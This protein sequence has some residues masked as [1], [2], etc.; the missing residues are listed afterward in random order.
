MP[1]LRI[2]PWL[3]VLACNP[4]ATDAPPPPPEPV[5]LDAAVAQV[6]LLEGDVRVAS[7][8]GESPAEVGLELFRPDVLTVPE[9]GWTV[10][11]LHNHYLVRLDD[12]LTVTVGELDLIDAEP[13]D[14]TRDEQLAE[15]LDPAEREATAGAVRDERVVGW[16]A[17]RSAGT[18]APP[19]LAH[20]SNLPHAVEP[21]PAADAPRAVASAE[22]APS[23]PKSA[24]RA[25]E[26]ATARKEAESAHIR[27]PVRQGV[28]PQLIGTRGQG[29]DDTVDLF[30]GGSS[31]DSIDEALA[32]GGGPDGIDAPGTREATPVVDGVVFGEPDGVDPEEATGVLRSVIRRR[33]GQLRYCYDK[34]LHVDPELSGRITM[35]W[36]VSGGRVTP[37]S[38][39]VM[40]DT[41]GSGVLGTCVRSKVLRWRFPEDVEATVTWSWTFRPAE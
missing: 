10:L 7:A 4:F 13:I 38:L 31:L 41:T 22:P 24:P 39:D 40:N 20:P 32:A 3:A 5:E 6:L 28:D 17:R 9:A 29:S 11:E 26:P 23:A 36:E 25:P 8:D 21:S 33:Q 27:E 34:A 2:L 37:S 35:E 30:G 18:S 19:S 12:D 15:L 14:R 16:H 1:T